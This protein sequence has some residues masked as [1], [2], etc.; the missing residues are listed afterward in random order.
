MSGT[1]VVVTQY[2]TDINN[3]IL[4]QAPEVVVTQYST[5]I[6]NSIL[7]QMADNLCKSIQY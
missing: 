5:D 2:S 7:S 4:Y 1:R 6:N 3:S